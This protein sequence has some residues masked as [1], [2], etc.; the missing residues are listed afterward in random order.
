MKPQ[1]TI[2]ASHQ[3]CREQL[4]CAN[5]F[6][7]DRLRCRKITSLQLL[8]FMSLY[9]TWLNSVTCRYYLP[10]FNVASVSHLSCI[11]GQMVTQKR[12]IYHPYLVGPWRQT[13]KV[14]E[15]EKTNT[16]VLEHSPVKYSDSVSAREQTFFRHVLSDLPELPDLTN[17]NTEGPVTP[18]FQKKHD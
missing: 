10:F 5:S 4:Q 15:I 9:S 13:E 12:E 16:L 18:D 6:L 7:R 1:L 8:P 14:F 2:C 11:W 3:M 17:R